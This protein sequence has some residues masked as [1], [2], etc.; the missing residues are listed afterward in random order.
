MKNTYI[1]LTIGPIYETLIN[2][3]KTRELWAGSYM[4]SYFMKT[5]IKELKEQKGFTFIIPYDGIEAFKPEANAGLFHDRFI[6]KPK[7]SDSFDELQKSIDNAISNLANIISNNS[8]VSKNEIVQYL[9]SYMQLNSIEIQTTSGDP[10]AEIN[11][12]LDAMELMYSFPMLE[13]KTNPLSEFFANINGSYLKK[14]AFGS[15]E[16]SF[17]SL[18]EIAPKELIEKLQQA[19][20][21]EFMQE[22]QKDEF[23]PYSFLRNEFGDNLKQYHKYF[24]I[25]RADGDSFGTHIKKLDGDE[26]KLR[27]FSKLVFEYT[28][29]L[30]KII[31][32]F[33][34]TCVFAGGDDLLAFMPIIYNGNTL[35]DAITK[36]DEK[37]TTIFSGIKVTLS[38]GASITYNK[39]PLYEALDMSYKALEKAKSITDS[40]GTNPKNAI[41]IKAT[42]H[43]GQ[44]FDLKLYKSN[45]DYKTFTSLLKNVLTDE[46]VEL[47]HALSHKLDMFKPIIEANSFQIAQIPNLFKN[48]FNESDHKG[49]FEKGLNGTKLLLIQILQDNQLELDKPKLDRYGKLYETNI[50]YKLDAL[51]SAL[52][53]IKLLRGDR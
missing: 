30:P 21:D 38:F 6:A 19:K 46:N 53:I 3:R 37:F 49:K 48:F 23:D 4:F 52:S 41:C 9:K 50:S 42:K 45:D 25:L 36:I 11:E 20:K 14:D 47:P 44:S 22:L 5:L 33:G 40:N 1:A 7:D 15:R 13:P 26:Q 18:Y 51:F 29:A 35:F 32:D 39:Y 27:E 16:G 2:A 28:S 10:I 31:S 17:E 12:K 24:A 8:T 43:S 34:G